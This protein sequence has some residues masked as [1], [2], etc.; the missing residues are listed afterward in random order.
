MQDFEL[1]PSIFEDAAPV[2]E[3]MD[4]GGGPPKAASFPFVLA[5][6]IALEPKQFLIDGFLG[7]HETSAWYGPPEAGKSIVIL[8]AGAHV[9][10]KLA[11]YGRAIIGGGP[12]LFVAAERGAI[13]KRR[14]RAWCLDHDLDD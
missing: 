8:D 13:S 3:D 5:K 9:A 6:D 1:D 7:R 2:W 4:G 10:A 14:V 12:V 11:Y